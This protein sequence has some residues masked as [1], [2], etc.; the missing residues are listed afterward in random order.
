MDF[1]VVGKVE[2]YRVQ[3]KQK[4]YTKSSSKFGTPGGDLRLSPMLIAPAW[5]LQKCASEGAQ[6]CASEG[7][8]GSQKVVTRGC[9]GALGVKDELGHSEAFCKERGFVMSIFH[10]VDSHLSHGGAEQGNVPNFP[11]QGD[12]EHYINVRR[13]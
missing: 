2:R 12:P 7:V 3:H 9:V 1:V 10:S 5:A 4:C 6:K 11:K 13:G 8:G